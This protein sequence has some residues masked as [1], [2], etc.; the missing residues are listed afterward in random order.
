MIELV[1]HSAKHR[2]SLVKLL[3]NKNVEKWLLQ[4]PYPYSYEDADFWLNKSVNDSDSFSFAIENNG[5]HVGG[6]G[7]HKK[8]DHSA[9]VGYWI[10]EEY[11]GKGFGTEALEK[12]LDVAFNELNLVRVHAHVF[13]GNIA[14]EKIL[15][16]CGFEYEGF[17][18]KVH[19]KN[20]D[21]INSKLYAK[22]I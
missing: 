22:V 18:K 4:V 11:W 5:L 14:S 8:Y 12:I 10:G 3:N 1:K 21:F 13:D 17:L 19:K 6:I 15:I 9:E 16:K 20:N 7:L 2:D